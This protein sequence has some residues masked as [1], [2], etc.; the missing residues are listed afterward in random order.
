MG[1][2][3]TWGKTPTDPVPKP[4]G[5][6]SGPR[7]APREGY[8]TCETTVHTAGHLPPLPCGKGLGTCW[9]VDSTQLRTVVS[10]GAGE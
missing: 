2:Q 9:G 8:S 5:D 4:V 3:E 7:G 1:S 10:S 6:G